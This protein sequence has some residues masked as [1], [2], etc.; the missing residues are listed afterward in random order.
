MLAIVCWAAKPTIRPM[1]AVEARMPV[2]S[3]LN[4]VNWLSASIAT[5]RKIARRASRRR[6]RNRVRVVRE[7]CDTARGMEGNL[8]ADPVAEPRPQRFPYSNWGP[9]GALLGVVLALGTGIVM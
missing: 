3:R 6:I 1:T 9:G 8:T 7:T 5:I 2:A 4:S